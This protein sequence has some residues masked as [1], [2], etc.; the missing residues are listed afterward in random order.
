MMQSL[1]STHP[2]DPSRHHTPDKVRHVEDEKA[3]QGSE[4]HF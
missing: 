4:V 2:F 1:S 3:G